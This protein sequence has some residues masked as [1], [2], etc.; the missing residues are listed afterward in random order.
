[1]R[2][3]RCIPDMFRPKILWINQLGR[4]VAFELTVDSPSLLTK[5]AVVAR[6]N[7]MSFL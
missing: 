6:G 1:M 4:I 3:V 7:L 5:R 2:L